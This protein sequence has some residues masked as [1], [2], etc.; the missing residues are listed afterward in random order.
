MPKRAKQTNQPPRQSKSPEQIKAE[1][2]QRAEANRQ[3]ALIRDK[4]YP[5][6]LAQ[7]KSIKQTNVFLTVVKMAIQQAFA[8]QKRVQTVDE[9]K[10]IDGVKGDMPDSEA[11]KALLEMFRYEKIITAEQLIE[12]LGNA[13]DSFIAEE[14][15]K[16]DIGTLKTD[17]LAPADDINPDGSK[18]EKQG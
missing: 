16:R 8:N 13:L 6:L 2:N 12:G 14:M 10:V 11:Y 4:V 15:S 5:F 18:E 3:R 9:L 7:K 17:F 1:M